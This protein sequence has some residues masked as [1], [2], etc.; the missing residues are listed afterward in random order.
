MPY[1]IIKDGTVQNVASADSQ[2]AAEQGWIECHERV[3]AGWLYDGSSF[4][5]PTPTDDFLKE[6]NKARAKQLLVET[7]WVSLPDVTDSSVNPYLINA[8]D[9]YSYRNQLRVILFNPPA[10]VTWPKKPTEEWSSP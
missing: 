7:D 6:I 1:A 3:E 2:F 8:Q 5:E 9:F 4:I 10:Q